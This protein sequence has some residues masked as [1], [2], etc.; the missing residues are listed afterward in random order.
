VRES[1]QKFHSLAGPSQGMPGT[2]PTPLDLAEVSHRLRRDLDLSSSPVQL[3][4]LSEPLPGAPLPSSPSPSVCTYFALG[5][6]RPLLVPLSHHEECEIGAFVLGIPPEGEL[7]KRLSTTVGEMEKDGYLL[8]GE[9][10]RIPRN[11]SAP[12]YVHYA[13]LGEGPAAPTAV[14]LFVKARSLMLVLEAAS[15]L[16]PDWTPPPMVLRP[17]CSI[18]PVLLKGSPL[19]ISVG[20]AGSRVYTGL[21]DGEMIVAV[22][23]DRVREFQEALHTVRR[24]NDVVTAEDQRRKDPAGARTSAL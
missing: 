19:A 15:R 17:M 14:L 22:R 20:C 6:T 24:A 7:G 4:Y 9:A 11:E 2:L 21:S 18:V 13:P 16:G 8:P 23:G 1:L 5:Q 3:T 12:A 10:T